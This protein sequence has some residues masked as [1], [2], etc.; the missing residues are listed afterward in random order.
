MD[1]V[2]AVLFCLCTRQL[3]AE[4]GDDVTGADVSAVTA[5]YTLGNI[6]D[7]DVVLNDDSVCGAFTL[8]L[9]AANAADLTHLHNSSALI[10]VAADRHNLLGL[11]NEGDD[12]LGADINTCATANTLGA[13]DLS[14]TVDQ[15]HCTKL[16]G[17][18]TVAKA[19]T[20]EGA[21]LAAL[22]A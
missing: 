1:N 3:L 17:A 12:V 14:N 9:H 10:L 6:N 5:L 21:H 22:A 2:H 8:A 19:N 16:A 20:S 11:G 7:S 4:V 15:I 13:V 18:D